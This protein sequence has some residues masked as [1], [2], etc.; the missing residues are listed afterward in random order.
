MSQSPLKL[1]VSARFLHPDPTRNFFKTKTLLYMD[2][3]MAHWLQSHGALVFLLPSLCPQ[4]SPPVESLVGEIDGLVLQG[5]TDVSPKQYGEEPLKPEWAGDPIR[6]VYELKLIEECV[7]QKKPIL[8]ICRGCQVLNVAFGGTLYQDI[9]S[10]LKT[11]E[12]HHDQERYDQNFHNV[13]IEEKSLLA[14]LYPQR[15]VARVNSIHHQ[16]VKKLGNG[17]VAEAVSP[18]DR[19]VEAIRHTGELFIFGFQ[20]HPEFLDKSH[21]ENLD[22]SAIM[23]TF[24]NAVLERK[25]RG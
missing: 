3:S 21:P 15:K 24:L 17:L 9:P 7:K 19:V 20:W 11:S 25:K 5:G 16:A 4:K 14:K 1:G 12:I 13:V 10:Q 2:Q 23:Q 18:N 6:D 8:G 22:S